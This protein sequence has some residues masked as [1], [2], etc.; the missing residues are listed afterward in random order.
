[1]RPSLWYRAAGLREGRT[2]SHVLVLQLFHTIFPSVSVLEIFV[3]ILSSSNGSCKGGAL[4]VCV[5]AKAVCFCSERP[6]QVTLLYKIVVGDQALQLLSWCCESRSAWSLR[7]LPVSSSCCGFAAGL[8]SVVQLSF[9]KNILL[10]R[11]EVEGDCRK[12]RPAS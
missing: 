5:T 8:P 4:C 6:N 9:C 3:H 7:K 10:F 12:Q 11:G 1:M 2:A